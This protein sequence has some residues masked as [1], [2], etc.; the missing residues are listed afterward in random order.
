MTAAVRARRVAFALALLALLTGCASAAPAAPTLDDAVAERRA[1]IDPA[2]ERARL[3]SLRAD[4]SALATAANRAAED[5][6]PR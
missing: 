2:A 6:P 4:R 5:C 1:A 3:A